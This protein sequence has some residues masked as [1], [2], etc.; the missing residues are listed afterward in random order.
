MTGDEAIQEALALAAKRLATARDK[1]Y[2]IE[3][4]SEEDRDDKRMASELI[5]DTRNIIA[6]VSMMVDRQAKE[7]QTHERLR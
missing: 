4:D 3:V 6:S 5:N 7:R 2:A 1:V